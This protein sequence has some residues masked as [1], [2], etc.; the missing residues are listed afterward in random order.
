MRYRAA[1]LALAGLATAARAHFVFVYVEGAE[2]R[3][4]FG[5]AA[6][7]DPST[8]ATRCEKTALTA[9]DAAGKETRLTVEK[10]DGNFYRAKLP[11][12][13]SVVVFGTTEA[14]VTQY[15][16]NPPML[17]WY[18]PKVIV[19][20]PFARGAEIGAGVPLEI[21]PVRDGEKVR[22]KV[23]A[24]GKPLPEVDVTVA[25][26]GTGE[27]KARTVKTNRDGLTDGFTDRGRYCVAVRRSEDQAG[28]F[29]GRKYALVRRT[30]TLVFDFPTPG[31]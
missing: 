3:L 20:D 16:D 22:F 10:G 30:A 23:V 24:N 29:G 12:D 27:D 18:F 14:G 19:G 2:A 9:R 11:T 4:V 7:P 8:P 25:L 31:K 17:T 5:H 1:V 15:A 21:I 26:S 28:E 6:A 13:N